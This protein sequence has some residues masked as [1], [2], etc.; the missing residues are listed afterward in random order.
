M[1]IININIY[2]YIQNVTEGPNN[3]YNFYPNQYLSVSFYKYN[4]LDTCATST[5]YNSI[6]L[7]FNTVKKYFIFK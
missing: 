5:F 3:L 7:F 6:F 1:N 4:F 2:I